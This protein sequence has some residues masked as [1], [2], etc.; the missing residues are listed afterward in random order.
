MIKAITRRKSLEIVRQLKKTEACLLEP[1]TT[2]LL[3]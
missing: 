3:G 1:M 2:M